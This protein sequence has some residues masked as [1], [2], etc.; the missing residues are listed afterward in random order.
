MAVPF[1]DLRKQYESLKGEID[2]ALTE[3]LAS[4]RYIGGPQ[5]AQFEREFAAFCE[6]EHAVAC[7]SGT[8]GLYLSMRALGIGPGD[9]VITTSYTFVASVGSIC[10]AG[11]KPVFVDVRPETLNI[12]PDRIEGKLTEHTRAIMPVHLYGQPAEMD[13]VLGIA[14]KHNLSVIED[15]CQAHGARYGGKRAGSLGTAASFSFYPTKNLGAFGDGGCVITSSAE[16]AEKVRS[17]ADHGRTTWTRHELEGINSRLDALQAAVLRVKLR[18]LEEWNAKRRHLAGLYLEQLADVPE[19]RP[20]EVVEGAEPVYHLFVVRVPGREAV[21]EKLKAREIGCGVYYGTPVHLQGAFSAL[22][23]GEG[24]FPAAEAA[25]REVLAL[26]LYPQMPESQVEE[27]VGA[28]K[29]SLI[30]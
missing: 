25:A 23:Y 21:M 2:S 18:Y 13:A 30:A 20:L 6:A 29:E 10:T 5:V 7:A 22:G 3:V 27:V 17:I 4:A 11:A 1:L 8:D 9:E 26:P 15:A 19:A 14:A 24:S 16:L 28:L 12:D